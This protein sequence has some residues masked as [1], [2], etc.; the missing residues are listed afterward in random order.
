MIGVILAAGKGSRLGNITKE[1]P[2][3]LLKLNKDIT[4]LDY[5]L[6]MLE[7]LKV[8]E[9]LIITGFES[10]K[11]EQHVLN[12]PNVK[13][14]FNPFWDHCNVLGSFY[15]ALPYINDDFF[16]LHADTL[17][18]FSIWKIINKM[19][20]QVILPFKRKTC[21]EEEMKVK[22][23][24][25]GN[26]KVISK[27]INSNDADGEFIGIAKFNHSFIKYIKRFSDK[28]FKTGLLN[29]Y[30][31]SVIQEA[32]N[33]DIEIETLDIGN[34]NFVEIDFLEDYELAK[35]LFSN[36]INN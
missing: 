36:A 4:L 14:I 30:M 35:K 21:G 10:S 23:D 1:S 26:L 22:H 29:L 16:F 34:A 3:S 20:E 6:I 11:I 25:N 13:C 31:E 12:K 15:M 9:I 24:S 18:D 17:V 33:E 27:L 5:N 19:K 2:K 8:K 32:I 28:L 7:K